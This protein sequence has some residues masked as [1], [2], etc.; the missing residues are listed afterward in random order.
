MS[1]R[2]CTFHDSY[3]YCYANSAAMLLSSIGEQVSPRLIEALTGVGLG[4]SFNPPLPFFGQ[5]QPP[6]LGLSQAL[7]L[8]GFGFDEDSTEQ[9]DPA[10][11]ERLAQAPAIVG[12]IDMSHLVYNPM[13]PRDPGVDHYVVILGAQDGRYRLHDPAGFAHVPLD[14]ANLA[15][16]W[17]GRARS[18]TGAA[19]TEAGPIP[20]GS[21][22]PIRTSSTRPPWRT[23]DA[24][25]TKRI[26]VRN[27]T[28]SASAVTRCSPWQRRSRPG[29]SRRSSGAT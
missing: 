8:L 23:S 27:D 28:A 26:D 9:A 14:A 13:R 18:P 5:L 20:A 22:R 1:G 17:A 11:L 29:S 7:E 24:S 12:P 15:T 3:W 2:E 4:A 25:I 21:G 10:P 16:A 19:T 6:D